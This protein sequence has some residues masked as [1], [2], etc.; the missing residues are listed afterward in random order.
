MVQSGRE[1][2]YINIWIVE[3]EQYSYLGTDSRCGAGAVE[4]GW[5]FRIK[6]TVSW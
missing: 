5:V 4:K 1:W 6:C 3:A 2:T